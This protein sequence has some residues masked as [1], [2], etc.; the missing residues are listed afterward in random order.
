MIMKDDPMARDITLHPVGCIRRRDECVWI[1]IDPRY[2]DGML[3]LEGFSHIHVIYW[4]HENDTESRRAMLQVNP[5]RDPA[6]PLTGVFATHSPKRPNLIGLTRCRIVAI[7]GLSIEVADLDARDGS[8]VLDI[9]CYIPDPVAP[10]DLRLP[11][12]V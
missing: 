3:G 8:P 12:W 5:R 4:F 1:D 7:R 6:N 11:S 9:K 2:K 10:E